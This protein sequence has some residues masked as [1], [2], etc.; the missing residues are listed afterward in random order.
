M[1][2]QEKQAK[3]SLS[4][5]QEDYEAKYVNKD[6]QA[7]QD[8]ERKK[9]EEFERMMK[10]HQNS[11]QK[12]IEDGKYKSK[13]MAEHEFMLNKKIIEGIENKNQN[14]PPMPKKPF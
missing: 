9:R 12:Q 13:G 8:Q 4:K 7:Y 3:N 11:L 14:S 6:V 10:Q 2:M 5:V 1:Q